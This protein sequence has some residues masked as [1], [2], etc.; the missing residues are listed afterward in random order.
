MCEVNFLFFVA[1]SVTSEDYLQWWC[2]IR[3]AGANS[4]FIFRDQ[5]MYTWYWYG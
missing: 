3:A 5:D 1:K 2:I 4:H